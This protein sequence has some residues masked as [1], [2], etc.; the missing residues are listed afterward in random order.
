[1]ATFYNQATLTYNG[2]TTTSNIATGELVEILSATKTPV[3]STYEQGDAITYIINIVNSGTVPLTGLTLTDNLGA[4]TFQSASLVPMSYTAD[5]L[6]YYINGTAQPSP[7]VTVGPPLTIT[8]ISVPAGSNATLIYEVSTNSYAP[9]A[10]G[11]TINNTATITGP[12][13]TTP[14][15]AEASVT[16]A[17][18]ARLTINKSLS[19]SIVSENGQLTYTFILQ[20]SGNT[21]ATTSD[22]L[23][24]TDTFH[25]TL[26]NLS[27][28]FNA[29]PWTEGTNYTYNATTGVFS[30][31]TGMLTVPAATISQD[32]TTGATLVTPGV[33]TLTVTGT[34]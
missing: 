28:S 5:S 9:L 13:I 15:L 22:N 24:V 2:N 29:T 25:P 19:P 26:R 31:V 21:A 10:Q 16:P 7:A 12:G 11:S 33:S 14:V 27:V 32:P 8:G 3:V 18:T 4:Y 23:I 1:M 30:T 6:H 34:V 17:N 20:N